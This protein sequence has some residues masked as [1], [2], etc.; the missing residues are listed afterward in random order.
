MHRFQ[1]WYIPERM[2]DGIWLYINNGV[3]PGN[4]LSAVIQNNL[5]EACYYADDE[6]LAN[7]P[8]YVDFFYNKAPISCWGS[9]DAMENWMKA[10]KERREASS[11]NESK[12]EVFRSET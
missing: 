5:K 6:N 2:M 4:F 8:A 10:H 9:Y 7:L 12:N 11:I 1:R 3:R